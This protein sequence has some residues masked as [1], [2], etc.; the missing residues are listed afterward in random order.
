MDQ[1]KKI[2]VRIAA[3]L[4]CTGITTVS[5]VPVYAYNAEDKGYGDVIVTFSFTPK[6]KTTK[7]V[8]EK[9]QVPVQPENKTEN[10]N[11]EKPSDDGNNNTNEPDVYPTNEE[12]EFK[13]EEKEEPSVSEHGDARPAPNKKTVIKKPEKEIVI[14]KGAKATDSPAIVG[15]FKKTIKKE[16]PEEP[17][18]DEPDKMIPYIIGVVAF[19]VV[20]ATAAVTGCF[21]ALWL[22]IL[23]VVFRKKKKHWKG[24]LTYETNLF[25]T[26]KG[27]N[28]YTEDMQDILDKGATL[29]ELKAIMESSGVETI[30]PVNTKMNIDIEGVEKEFDADEETFYR[31][32]SG[33]SGSAVVTF[34]NGAAKLDFTVSINLG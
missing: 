31:E 12:Q 21:S 28:K 3:L 7:P 15:E 26:V 4:M 19:G 5:S 32:L 20:T 24:L 17:D 6:E 33:K 18:K 10:S 11:E 25:M 9:K 14:E 27:R 23:G 8:E 1:L 29:D 22:L 34:Y 30:L 13:P 2:I 16:Y